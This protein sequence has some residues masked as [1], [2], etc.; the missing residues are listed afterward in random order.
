ME[1]VLYERIKE[2]AKEIC[3]D[4]NEL[5][6]DYCNAISSLKTNMNIVKIFQ[7]ENLLKE[8]NQIECAH[9]IYK[10]Y[11]L[12]NSKINTENIYNFDV[13]FE[14]GLDETIGIKEISA[15]EHYCKIEDDIA[16]VK[17]EII[18]LFKNNMESVD[19]LFDTYG[20]YNYELLRAAYILGCEYRLFGKLI[21]HIHE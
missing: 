9:A 6:N 10:G 19:V 7:L 15:S 13:I 2:K 4:Y 1:T 16:N 5:R 11:I 17:Q 21:L 20:N 8:K 3:N 18:A 12:E 14:H